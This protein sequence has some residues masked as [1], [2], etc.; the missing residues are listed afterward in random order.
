MKKWIKGLAGFFVLIIIIFLVIFN[1]E[2]HNF[3]E[4][5]F[6]ADNA[7]KLT[8][9]L[10][11]EEFNGR[12][13]GSE[14]NYK[15]LKYV[16]N[17]FKSVGISPAGDKGTYYQKLKI[18][19]P[20]YNSVPEFSVRD[21]NNNIVK[22]FKYGEDFRDVLTGFGGTGS[23]NGKLYFYSQ[24]INKIPSETLKS[25]AIL[26][27]SP[28][29]DNDIEYAI[30]K[31]CRAI[32]YPESDVTQKEVFDMRS[33]YGKS[34]VIFVISD[35]TF[36]A[37]NGYMNQGMSV[38][39]KVDASFKMTDT[40]NIL[41]KIEGRNKNAGY[42]IISSHIDADGQLGSGSF[43][44]G[45]LHD[46]SGTAMM[47]EFARAM[48]V[49]KTKPDKT[50]IFA[51][52]N[53]FGEK[54]SGSNYYVDHPLYPLDKSE[55]I[56]LDNIGSNMGTGLFFSSSGTTGEALMNKLVSYFQDKSVDPLMT[57][58]VEGNDNQPFYMKDVPAV[59]ISG[60]TGSG[61]IDT[62]K[63]NMSFISKDKI[64]SIGNSLMSCVHREFYKDL[65]HGLLTQREEIIIILLI[66]IMMLVYLIKSVYKIIPSGNIKGIKL[67]NIFYSTPFGL[68]D[69]IAQILFTV[70]LISFLIAFIVYIPS[71]FDIVSYSG[72]YMS[73]YSIYVIAQNALAYLRDLAAHGLGK[74]QLGFNVTYIISFSIM[75]SVVLVLCSVTL[76]FIVGT[77][78]GAL[79]GFRHRGG[80]SARFLG[81]IT[82]MS[83]PDVLIAIL[84]Q[85]ICAFL[86]E[87]NILQ[88]SSGE[89]GS[90]VF[91]F[92]C[93]AII[94]TAYIS[95]IAQIAVKEEMNKDYIMAA[96]AKGLSNF[97]IMKNHLLISVVIKVVEALPS[98]LNIIISNLIIVE[99]LF[100]YP[101]IVCQLFS[102]IKENDVKTCVGL[103][104]GIGM[105]YCILIMIFKVIALIINP[106]KRR[107]ATKNSANI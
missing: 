45:S 36:E 102:Y 74:T 34:A 71:K 24:D 61:I 20:V 60:N 81:S 21:N 14:G 67:E 27:K 32:I 39:M 33:K 3:N 68:I 43:V 84:I 40:P 62:P 72:S 12:Q 78:N 29:S 17:Y 99:Y 50:I 79:S 35:S 54:L 48:S 88:A 49:Q 89:T 11:S 76:A 38:N 101:G 77:I 23:V 107:S 10:S 28:M 2:D 93:L 85:L 44:P 105:V 65:F 69:K 104:I 57:Q 15:A 8:E 64:A 66:I 55:V 82:V 95:R 58:N 18:M 59:L 80:S 51:A 106:F 19:L 31:G 52:W 56:V 22:S 73:N 16:E 98:V 83:L 90:F 41:G 91:P 47:M 37:L 26:A 13:A 46:A 53:G 94:P 1:I 4:K 9:K 70:V 96:K 42:L 100:S 97:S 25:S 92:I 6:R 86:Y 63:D 75:K 103:I 7:Y 87:N 30:D 5:V